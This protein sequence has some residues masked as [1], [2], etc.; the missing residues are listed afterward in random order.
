M[1]G[2]MRTLNEAVR[3]RAMDLMRET[4]A[5]VTSAYGATFDL[6]LSQP[7]PV[8]YN[9]PKLVEETLPVMRRMVGDA[10]LIAPKPFMP[11]EDFSYFQKV[12]PGFYYFLGVGNKAKGIT[13]GWHTAE[14]DVDEESLVVGVKVMANVLVDY[15]ERHAA[16][17]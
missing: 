11:A 6:E 17:R 7:N 3:K 14:F 2:T 1:E 16:S 9:E 15:L 12:I 5:A 10:N 8:T 4:L 13:A